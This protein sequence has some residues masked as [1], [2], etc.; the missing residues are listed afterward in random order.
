MEKF[1][2]RHGQN[3]PPLTP[4]SAS[5][6]GPAT[7][8]ARTPV[9]WSGRKTAVGAVLAIG[10]AAGGGVAAAHA[11]PQGSL[12][13]G[14]QHG[15]GRGG[16]GGPGMPGGPG[17]EGGQQSPFPHS[18]PGGNNVVPDAVLP[19]RPEDESAASS[20][21]SSSSATSDL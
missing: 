18:A 19:S 15:P 3:P 6:Q 21:S 20:S 14:E 5:P 17:G 7:S 11:I 16:P 9:R 12:T 13:S 8:P 4:G 1:S 2:S 10:I